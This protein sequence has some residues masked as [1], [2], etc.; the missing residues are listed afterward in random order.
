MHRSPPT[1][2]DGALGKGL[3]PETADHKKKEHL[4]LLKAEAPFNLVRLVSPNHQT[5]TH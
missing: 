4:R 2:D 1:P 5:K 3:F